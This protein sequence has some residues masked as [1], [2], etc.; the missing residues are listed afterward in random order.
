M[1]IERTVKIKV[2][3]KDAVS[4]A[5][6]IKKSFEDL[7]KTAKDLE[8]EISETTDPKKLKL[9]KKQL[10]EV[11]K[12]LGKTEE[13]F[14]KSKKSANRFGNAIRGIGTAIKA[15][16]IGLLVAGVAKLSMAFAENS[17]VS[18]VFKETFETI[19][20]IFGDFVTAIVNAVENVSKVTNGFE[21][22][23][24]TVLGAINIALTPLKLA[25]LGIKRGVQEVQLAFEKT[26]FFGKD[27][28]KI[29]ELEES[30]KKTNEQIINTGKKY[31]QSAE[32]II[33]NIGKAV[34]EIT[35]V[36]EES[37][38]KVSKIDIEEK[39][40]Q[41]KAL[42]KLRE[43]TKIAIAQNELI[44][45]TKQKEAELQR[46]IR[47]ETEND[48]ATRV[49]ANNELKKILEDSNRLQIANAQK[50][51]ELAKLEVQASNGSLNSRLQLIDAEKN[52]QDVL[53]TTAGFVSEQKT[54]KTALTQEE[55]DLEQ[56]VIDAK[57]ERLIN[58]KN[59]Q[60]EQEENELL[61][62][63][64]LKE[65]LDFE[66]ELLLEDLERKKE[67]YKE[68][69]QA[70]VDAE[71]AYLDAKQ[72][73]DQREI[74][75]D[76]EKTKIKKKNAKSSAEFEQNLA[77]STF[78]LLGS[79]AKEGSVLA[80]GVAIAQ[81]T[82]STFQGINKALAETTDFTPTQSLRFANAAIVGASGFANVASILSTPE[83]S[84]SAPSGS[85]SQSTP[86]VQAPS[87]NLVQGTGTDQ[88]AESIQTQDR[89]IKAYV[90]SSD[91]SSQQE[92][93]RNAVETA[94]L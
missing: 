69:T 21:S 53:D 27:K 8:K 12:E 30:I 46:Q 33:N 73:L 11:N 61:K 40:K 43:E 29:K 72:E 77:N 74:Q 54:N 66:K 81:A 71:Q 2:D 49:K 17:K 18:K 44:L 85:V 55:I 84:Q 19:N 10:S 7:T 28:E 48:I 35:K 94:T 79:L 4:G 64:R 75:L 83:S 59:F 22:L 47:D 65:N 16:G 42:V 15:T 31:K 87:F 34:E 50:A 1:G 92:L 37:I 26:I 9:L 76:N 80:K 68:G 36:T 58:E 13:G 89:P 20:L 60:A 82:V 52:Y 41:A 67:L 91:V 3:N 14:K 45:L 25:F 39:S 51:I 88:I 24:K 93:D 63:E 86:Q 78:Q 90:V 70:R 57:N 23:K 62:L 6:E 5:D 32:D 38:K 56:S